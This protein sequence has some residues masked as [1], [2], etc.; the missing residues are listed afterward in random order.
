MPCF[1]LPLFPLFQSVI[2]WVF[3]WG[4]ARFD[5]PIPSPSHIAV[6]FFWIASVQSPELHAESGSIPPSL[7]HLERPSKDFGLRRPDPLFSAGT[8]RRACAHIR[9]KGHVGSFPAR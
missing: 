9:Q 1:A 8:G 3:M 2:I 6:V 4:L 7:T 5:A